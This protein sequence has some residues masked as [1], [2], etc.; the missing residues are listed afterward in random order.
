[1]TTDDPPEDAGR[2]HGEPHAGDPSSPHP[3]AALNQ[4]AVLSVGLGVVAF[5]LLVIEP[6]GSLV[7]SMPAVTTGTHARREILASGGTQR[8][9]DLAGAGLAIGGATLLLAVVAVFLDLL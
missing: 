9:A 2:P 5:V 6:F 3:S 1:M 8:G 7:L 4:R